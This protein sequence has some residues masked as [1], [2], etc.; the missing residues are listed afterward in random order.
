MFIYAPG[1]KVTNLCISEPDQGAALVLRGCNGSRWQVFTAKQID[2]TSAFEWV[3][4]ATGDVVSADGIRSPLTGT[5]PPSEPRPGV[6][7]TPAA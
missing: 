4:S 6:E 7:W 2:G 3:N 5:K 1:G